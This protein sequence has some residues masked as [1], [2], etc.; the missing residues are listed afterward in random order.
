MAENLKFKTENNSFVYNNID[1][2]I[3][4]L[5]RLYTW[6]SANQSVPNGWAL[7]TDEDWKR[8]EKYLGMPDSSLDKYGNRGTDITIALREFGYS[9]FNAKLVGIGTDCAVSGFYNLNRSTCFWAATEI[10]SQHAWCREINHW[11][12]IGR[13]KD[14]KEMKFSVRCIK[15]KN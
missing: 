7:P 15:K 12:D 9:G 2:N 1:S 10:D 13:F 5:G 8:L 14:N 6:E 3:K 4:R 11:T